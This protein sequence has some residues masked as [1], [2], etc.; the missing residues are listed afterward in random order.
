MDQREQFIKDFVTRGKASGASKEEVTAKLQPALQEY[1]I[2]FSAPQQQDPGTNPLM[3]LANLLIPQ[4]TKA[5]T[6]GS[7]ELTNKAI[8]RDKTAKNVGDVVKNAALDTVD[9]AKMLF[10]PKQVA[11][12]GA[13]ATPAGAQSL[14]AR[15]GLG[16]TAGGLS[17]AS[18]DNATPSSVATG[19]MLGAGFSGA[20]PVVGKLAKKGAQAVIDNPLTRKAQAPFASAYDSGMH[21]LAQ[22]LGISLPPSAVSKS[23]VVKGGEG[24]VE[25]GTFFGG[26]ITKQIESAHAR[27]DELATSLTEGVNKTPD[28]KNAGE[29]IKKG[30]DEYVDT[31][32]KTKGEMYDLYTPTL[33]RS[34]ADA[35]ATTE[36]V[37]DILEQK[38][39]SLA[40]SNNALYEAILGRL[41]GPDGKPRPVTIETLKQTRTMIGSMMK[42][43]ADP[44]ATG[45]RAYLSRLYA[46]LSDDLDTSIANIDP[47][48]GQALQE[49]S[50][51]YKQGLAKINSV[52]GKK[53]QKADPEKLVNELVK[54]NSETSIQAVK[55]IIGEEGFRG[56]QESFLAKVY[57]S[58]L[59]NGVLDPQKLEKQLATYG[60]GTLTK[61]LSEE[62]MGKLSAVREQLRQLDTVRGSLRNQPAQG[63]QTAFLAGLGG[64]SGLLFH[65][66]LQFAKVILGELA[67]S[68]LYTT[69]KGQQYLTQGLNLAQPASEAVSSAKLNP[70]L[71]ELLLR[72]GRNSLA[73]SSSQ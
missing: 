69:Q 20:A 22:H 52:L 67:G 72:S 71:S 36:A 14:L 24:L 26:K 49:A 56:L 43:H 28:F 12:I 21:E 13:Y 50:A 46:S 58:S 59:K 9:F 68:K 44:I 11:E 55:E 15:L 62:Q 53:I 42:N 51:F 33:G 10:N 60:D 23:R 48:A 41:I 25:R 8:A 3:G 40:P 64:V 7:T 39:K 54:P 29:T 66:P 19:T 45:D 34:E 57:Q 6:Q 4:T 27:L 5:V 61:L 38:G 30:F 2:H 17:A 47:Q 35:K 18:Q 32:N 73:G 16:A 63:S 37:V 70:L 65:N 1:D 31:F